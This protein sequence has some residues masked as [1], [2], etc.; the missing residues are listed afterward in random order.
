MALNLIDE[1]INRADIVDIIG[2]F[3]S[4]HKSGAN[5]FGLCPFHPDSNPSMSVSPKKKIFKCFSC[6]AS[7]NVITFIQKFKKISYGEAIRE[8]AKLAGFS[9]SAI[10]EYFN[11]QDKRYSQANWKLFSLNSDANDLF[12]QLLFDE[13]NKKYLQYLLD[14]K[15]SLNTIKKFEIGFCGK[16]NAKQIC[17]DLLANKNVNPQAKWN[18]DDLLKTSLININE[19]TFEISDYFY[20]RITFPI[21]DNNGYI[22]G[23]IARDILLDSELKYLTSRETS[24]FSKSNTLYNMD[25]MFLEKP[26]TLVILEGNIDLISLYESGM[27]ESTHS[28]VALMGTALTRNHV[29]MIAKSGFIKNI[30]LWFDNDEAGAKST[31]VNGLQ[32]LKSGLNVVVAN[33][34]T[35]YKDVNEIMIKES[36]QKVLHILLDPNKL[37]FIS[38]YITK[39]LVNLNTTNINSL[40]EEVLALINKHGNSLQW[41]HYANLISK[42]TKLAVEDITTAYK[43][44]S[45]NRFLA[46]KEY[47]W[48]KKPTAK[49]VTW[50]PIYKNLVDAFNI[51]MKAIIYQP[52]LAEL[53]Y[54][55]LVHKETTH[56]IISDY[57]YLIKTLSLESFDDKQHLDVVEKTIQ[58]LYDMKKISE[59]GAKALLKLVDDQKIRLESNLPMKVSKNSVKIQVQHIDYYCNV[60]E[61]NRLLKLL[62]ND[63]ISDEE[64]IRATTALEQVRKDIRNFAKSKAHRFSK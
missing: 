41:S 11:K 47:E 53:V 34:T 61:K 42:L 16:N 64:K 35:K 18:E 2:K 46:N 26:E 6:G 15:L 49:K 17:Y 32:F 25:K 19:K 13:D 30:I 58:Q 63:K 45:T 33:N 10:E 44:I 20:N 24:L 62:S 57:M 52:S 59:K 1:I 7:G 14:R 21:K 60:V 38:Y 36:K 54:K 28:A 37:D 40:V 8:A 39:R 51:L 3:V 50:D 31:I 56:P 55:E 4:L 5:Y 12:K 29:Q 27:N 22:V 43:K 9:Q 48:N 23:F